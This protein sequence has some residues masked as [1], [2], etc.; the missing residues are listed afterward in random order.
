MIQRGCLLICMIAIASCGIPLEAE[1][2]R[3]IADVEPPVSTIDQES[4]DRATAAMF[5]V[6]E[7]ELLIQVTRD[8]SVPVTV[9]ALMRSLLDGATASEARAGIRTSIPVGTEI[10][11]IQIAAE[12]VRVDL[13]RDFA[14]VGGTE[15]LLSVAQIVLTLTSFEG[16]RTVSFSLDG[17]PTDVPVRSGALSGEPVTADD[18]LH[19]IRS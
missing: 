8:L 7:D 5:L 16:V 4:K 14:A 17:V 11:Q 10:N 19:L 12:S 1:P 15:E 3:I 13:S 9:E 18:Y 2:E 6:G